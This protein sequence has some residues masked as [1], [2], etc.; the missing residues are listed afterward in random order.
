MSD[1]VDDMGE[2]YYICVCVYER[3]CISVW[4]SESVSERASEQ[5]SDRM[6]A[7]DVYLSEIWDVTSIYYA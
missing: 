3:K 4:V 1:S 2:W 6:Q 5:F 7:V